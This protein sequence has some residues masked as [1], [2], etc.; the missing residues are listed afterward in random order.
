MAA[1][2]LQFDTLST[3]LHD[4]AAVASNAE[5]Q[6]VRGS[7]KR[8]NHRNNTSTNE[9]GQRED[10][11]VELQDE[12][13][14]NAPK[15]EPEETVSS[16]HPMNSHSTTRKL[17]RSVLFIHEIVV[18]VSLKEQLGI[19]CSS[20]IKYGRISDK[21][22]QQFEAKKLQIQKKYQ[23]DISIMLENVARDGW[24]N[25][26]C[27]DKTYHGGH[28]YDDTNQY[29]EDS[30]ECGMCR[31]LEKKDS[32]AESQKKNDGNGFQMFWCFD[33]VFS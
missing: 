19:Y 3:L 8:K 31:I 32:K 10:F 7:S 24:T 15:A 16:R 11:E 6:S 9:N 1:P 21:C 26:L 22:R 25:F 17:R 12:K 14:E 20:R 2:A 18:P 30:E 29:L 5:C 23:Q 4:E 33:L 28:F 27:F 13:T